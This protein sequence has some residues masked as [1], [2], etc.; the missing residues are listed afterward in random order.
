[1][2]GWVASLGKAAGFYAKGKAKKIATDKLLGKGKKKPQKSQQEGEPE[3]EEKGGALAIRPTTSLVPTGPTAIV[4]S[5]GGDFVN[6]VA[7]GSGG[8]VEDSVINIKTKV[9]TIDKILKGTL[10][11]EKARKRKLL[12]SQEQADAASQEASLEGSKKKKKGP[13]LKKFVPKIALSA[14]EKLKNF[15]TNIVFGYVAIQLLPLLPALLK[16]V[17]GLANVIGWITDV[18]LGILTALTTFID[19]GYKLYDMGMGLVK[20][21]V[22]EEGA[23]KIEQFMGVIKDLINGFLVWKIIGQ[24]IFK[25]IVS[26]ITRAFRIARVIIKRAFR[27]AKKWMLQFGKGIASKLRNIPGFKNAVG[28]VGQVGGNIL[29]KGKGL[30][31]KTTG[32]LKGPVGAKVSTL[33]RQI[34]GKAANVIAPA[35]KGAMPA[36]KGFF[37]RIPILGPVIVGIVSLMTGDPPG[38]AIFKALGAALGGALGTFIPIPVLGTLIGETIGVF[39]GEVLYSL[40][41]KKD[42]G[43]AFRFIGESFKKIFSVG[44]AII[45]W[46]FGGGLFELL[47]K[48]GGLLL[49]FGKW[50]FLE[51]IPWAVKK[52]A[53]VGKIIGEWIGS[54]V[55]R[56]KSSF[57]MFEIP[58]VGIQDM[59]YNIFDMRWP[60]IWP[61]SG[62]ISLGIGGEPVL[63]F[64]EGWRP[65][66]LEN[67]PRLPRILGF[68]WQNVPG[69]SAL[70]DSDGEVKGFPK[71]WLLGN[72]MFMMSHTKNAFFPSQ[73]SGKVSVPADSGGSSSISRKPE[74]IE[75]KEQEDPVKKEREK[76]KEKNKEKD[77]DK[78]NLQKSVDD[79]VTGI[80]KVT[81]GGNWTPIEGLPDLGGGGAGTNSLTEQAKTKTLS[82]AALDFVSGDDGQKRRERIFNDAKVLK[83][84]DAVN[85]ANGVEALEVL[86]TYAS[87]E[88]G[89]SQTVVVTTPSAQ[90]VSSISPPPSPSILMIEVSG[91]GSDDP[92]ES[93]YMG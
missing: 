24:K 3:Y 42:P 91:G 87:Y 77:K 6:T 85:K 22:G 41:I 9:I 93:L 38:Q 60:D 57:P 2:A 32:F 84:F 11:A 26:T 5:P 56:W 61:F 81:S 14:W 7:D 52:I 68:L 34:F 54:G 30:L 73:G 43:E 75:K 64:L 44:G 53:G 4:P 50:L 21:L 17:K 83:E 90:E 48:G 12:K 29:S 45:D 37:G 82:S 36:V 47:S 88:D 86:K 15:F 33:S 8:S 65:D 23:K 74:N 63:P 58:K 76:L 62:R 72:P 46:I 55:E 27:F 67:L 66:F 13:G 16:F 1:M 31:S 92:F 20:N 39:V 89:T 10:A 35:L 18:G 79:L 51:A 19:W 59:I 49:K 25:A 70:V 28:K 78:E 71:F 40:I 80:E 69:L